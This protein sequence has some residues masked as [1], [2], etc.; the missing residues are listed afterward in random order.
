MNNLLFHPNLPVK[1]PLLAGMLH[2]T[3]QTTW[4]AVKYTGTDTLERQY[5]TLSWG[6]MEN[7]Q[8]F[9]RVWR[10]GGCHDTGSSFRCKMQARDIEGAQLHHQWGQSGWN[11]ASARQMQTPARLHKQQWLD[12]QC[13]YKQV[14]NWRWCGVHL[15]FKFCQICGWSVWRLDKF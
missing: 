6:W 12:A 2:L 14:K 4:R 7:A 10:A 13:Q 1:P 11:K 5:F 8:G 3:L 15:P 9:S